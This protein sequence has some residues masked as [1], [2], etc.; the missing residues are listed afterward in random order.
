MNL[1]NVAIRG[2]YGIT[3]ALPCALKPLSVRPD[4]ASD[5]VIRRDLRSEGEYPRRVWVAISETRDAIREFDGVSWKIIRD[6]R[7]GAKA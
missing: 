1:I 2:L 4:D 5:P 3:P 7:P 6:K